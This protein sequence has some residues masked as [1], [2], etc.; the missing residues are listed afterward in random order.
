MLRTSPRTLAA[1]ANDCKVGASAL[2][3]GGRKCSYIEGKKTTFHL[4]A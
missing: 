3:I 4:W 2:H 1:V